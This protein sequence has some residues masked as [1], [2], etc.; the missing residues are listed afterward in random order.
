MCV[1]VHICRFESVTHDA[2]ILKICIHVN[3]LCILHLYSFGSLLRALFLLNVLSSENKD[4]Y[5]YYYYYYYCYINFQFE[6]L[7]S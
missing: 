5:Y 2:C 1:P 3:H 7:I 6:D 4:Y